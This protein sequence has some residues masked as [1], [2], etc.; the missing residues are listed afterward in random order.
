M[1]HDIR[2]PMNAIL[3]MTDVALMHI[4]EKSRV[5]DALNK[6]TVSGKHLLGL[7]N[8]VLDMSRIESGRV[9]LAEESF[10]LSDTIDN[11]LTILRSQLEAKGLT[12]DMDIVSLEHEN[13]IGDEQHLQQ[14]FMNILG[15]AVKFT[16]EGGRIGIRIEEKPSHIDGSGCYEFMFEDTGIGMEP[17]FIKSVFEPFSRAQNSSGNKIE[18]TGLGMSIAVSIARM[19]HGDIKVESVLGEG[20]KFTVTVYLKPDDTAR[21]DTTGLG[22]LSVLVAD[23]EEAACDAVCEMLKSLGISAEYVL[24]G[25]S[26]VKRAVEAD[27]NG[28]GFSAVFL[29]WKMPG[30]NGSE[31]AAEIREKL[32]GIPISFSPPTT[33]RI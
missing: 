29:D 8:E 5:V 21:D 13:V 2:T 15:N 27:K 31:T 18:G 7:I 30:K 4:D 22:G 3:G 19:M 24:D 16:P 6:I 20:S 33:A 14:I 26:A 12:L 10:N 9:R 23:D 32:G 1:S 11:V 17:E 28:T 25:D